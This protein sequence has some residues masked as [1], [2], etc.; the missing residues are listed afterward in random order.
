MEIQWCSFYIVILSGILL[1]N[2]M[3]HGQFWNS[4]SAL[5]DLTLLIYKS[6]KFKILQFMV[7][8]G[9]WPHYSCLLF[10]VFKIH[11]FQ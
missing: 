5:W 3:E 6:L 11:N 8:F 9:V 4:D 7:H 10:A 1:E 2:S